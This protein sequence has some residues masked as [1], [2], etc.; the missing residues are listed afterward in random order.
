[1][2]IV[3]P[4]RMH[5]TVLYYLGLYQNPNL[6]IASIVLEAYKNFDRAFLILLQETDRDDR[7]L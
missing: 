5:H 7:K 2:G 6:Y 1:M 4:L 3:L